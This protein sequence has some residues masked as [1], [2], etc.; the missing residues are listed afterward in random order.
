MKKHIILSIAILLLLCSG[1]QMRN[2]KP[3]SDFIPSTHAPRSTDFTDDTQPA[4]PTEESVVKELTRHSVRTIV[5]DDDSFVDI[6]GKSWT[7]DFRL[8]FVDYPTTE[9]S[10]CNNEIDKIYR[11]IIREQENLAD[12]NQPLTVPTINYECYYTG[13]LISLNVWAEHI[14]GTEEHSVYCFR[15]DGTL[16][17]GSEILKAV[18]MDEEAFLARLRELLEERYT[19][20]NAADADVVTYDTN[21]EKTLK[22]IT[23]AD[24]IRI[25]ADSEDKVFALVTLFDARGGN[26]LIELEVDP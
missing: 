18:W 5:Q 4:A 19:K 25:F 15:A 24:D 6:Y 3:S 20:D 22:P 21:L 17:A 16:A 11:R 23:A 7:Y 2:R 13:A 9:A 14:D 8:P 12:M 26:T 1:C 10:V